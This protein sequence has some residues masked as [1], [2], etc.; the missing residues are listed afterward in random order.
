MYLWTI[1]LLADIG[2]LSIGMAPPCLAEIIDLLG[3]NVFRLRDV[4]QQDLFAGK[5][6]DDGRSDPQSYEPC[7][8]YPKYLQ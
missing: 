5:G 8:V 1:S 7:R 6:S 4:L 2:L 3:V